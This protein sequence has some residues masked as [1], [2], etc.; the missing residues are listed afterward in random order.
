[1]E[2]EFLM[3][4]KDLGLA[5]AL[6]FSA[7]GSALGI[8]IAGQAAVGVWKKCYLQNKPAPFILVAFI[9]APMTQTFYGMILMIVINGAIEKGLYLWTSGLL[10]GVA[11]GASAWMQGKIAAAAADSYAETGGK[12]MGQYLA[13]IGII[14]SVAIFVMIFILVFT[15]PLLGG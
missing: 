7:F 1:M 14:E 4:L 13:A 9:G 10:A 12:G 6:A 15:Q 5:G 3:Q 2:K 11:M 8:G